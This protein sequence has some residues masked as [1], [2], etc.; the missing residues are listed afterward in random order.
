[1]AKVLSNIQRDRVGNSTVLGSELTSFFVAN[2]DNPFLAGTR[3][4]RD[5]LR[6]T[7]NVLQPIL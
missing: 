6:W 7:G 4:L 2:A 3:R 1:V 5:G